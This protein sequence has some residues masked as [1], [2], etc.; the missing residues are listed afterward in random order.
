MNETKSL[1]G[2]VLLDVFANRLQALSEEMAHVIQRTG[3]TV[4]VKESLDYAASVVDPEGETISFSQ[5]LG[6]ALTQSSMKEAL[7]A[8]APYEEGD[9]VIANDPTTSGGLCTHLSDTYLWKPVFA[10]GK[11]I[12]FLCCFI[13][14]TD[15]GGRVP[16]SISPTSSEIFQEGLRIPPTKLYHRGQLN[17]GVLGIYLLNGRIPDQNW[18]DLKAM[19]AAMNTAE[20]R[21]HQMVQRFG[22]DSVRRAM[23]ELVSYTEELA[24]KTIETIPDGEYSFADFVDDD[25]VSGRPIHIHLSMRVQGDEITLDFSGTDYEVRSALNV[26][27]YGKMH[28]FVAHP[29]TMYLRAR[30]PHCPLNGGILRPLHIVAEPGSVLYPRP[31]AA[32]GVRMATVFRLQDAILAALAQA[33]PDVVPAAPAGQV[34][35][36]LVSVPD[37]RTGATKVSQIQPMLGGSGGRPCKDG[38]DGRGLS[39]GSGLMNVPAERLEVDMPVVMRAFGFVQDSAA[40][41]RFR[42]GAAM[43][44]EVEVLSHGTVVTARGMERYRFRPWGLR[45]GYPGSLGDTVLHY[46]RPT[47]KHVGKIDVLNLGPGDTIRFVSPSGGGWGDPIE[48]P[49]EAV[50]WDAR[51]GFVSLEAASE[52]YGVVICDGRAD[53]AATEERRA[54]IAQGRKRPALDVGPERAA[55]EAKWPAAARGEFR[56]ILADLPAP[57]RPYISQLLYTQLEREARA[58][59]GI[60][61]GAVRAAWEAIRSS[62]RNL[63][64]IVGGLG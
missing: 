8:C 37:L 2:R 44:V 62:M 59:S 29:L 46:D 14:S 53:R 26:P 7:D 64:T 15:I 49:V 32:V 41:G 39:V 28:Q 31:T 3:F 38:I 30:N 5:R 4:Y 9:V 50:E 52:Y 24:R 54:Q 12:S 56:G 34:S 45:G 43:Q 19:L 23:R 17:Q 58:G 36:P 40:P 63:E 20:E 55:Y 16:G 48:R 35:I 33:A 11:I 51:Q 13:H 60:S 27:I 61:P 6:V 42:G 21:I 1:G 47:A 10:E 57:L 22:L 25:M 18:G